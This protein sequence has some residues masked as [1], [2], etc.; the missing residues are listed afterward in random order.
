[1]LHVVSEVCVC[2]GGGGGG[3]GLTERTFQEDALACSLKAESADLVEIESRGGPIKACDCQGHGGGEVA[4]AKLTSPGERVASAA[5]GDV[6]LR[7]R[8][9]RPR[10]DVLDRAIGAK[11]AVVH[12][13]VLAGRGADLVPA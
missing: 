6:G 4:R 12:H 5:L 1:M 13:N 10:P 3:G 11:D 8:A 9:R 7:V 2:V